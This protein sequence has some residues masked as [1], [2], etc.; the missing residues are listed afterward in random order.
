MEEQHNPGPLRE[1]PGHRP[2]RSWW[3]G[4]SGP[5]NLNP[6]L[7]S[8]WRIMIS[9][10]GVNIPAARSPYNAFSGY[11]EDLRQALLSSL[12]NQLWQRRK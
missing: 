9:S 1:L 3:S 6:A 8:S 5:F 11:L 7:L 2:G 12:V 10:S 4:R